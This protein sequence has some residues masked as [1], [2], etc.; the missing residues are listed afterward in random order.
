MGP[1]FDRSNSQMDEVKRFEAFRSR[2]TQ[3]TLVD[4]LR[5]CQ[6]T[7]YNLC[8]QVLRHPQNAEDASQKVFMTIL[9]QLPRISDGQHFRRWLRTVCLH[10][11][12][13]LKRKQETVR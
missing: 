1:G 12:L 13:D 7:V 2:P 4:L 10:V 11:S 3:E 6:G 8:S 9:D 5:G